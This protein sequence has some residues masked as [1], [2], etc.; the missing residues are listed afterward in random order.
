MTNR[1]FLTVIMG[2][3]ATALAACSPGYMKASEL[4]SKHQGPADC[5]A[6]CVELG[7][8][9][10]ALVLVSDTLPGC[11]CQPTPTVAPAA[12]APTP[13]APASVPAPALS[14]APPAN[15]APAAPISDVSQ[16][17]ASA[18]TASY[19]VATMAAAAAA[20]ANQTE[21]QR[22]TQQSYL[23]K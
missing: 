18:A 2:V 16:Q 12:P 4:E 15:P 8:R 6:R 14:G 9:M 11:V 22:R 1:R 7:M 23:P 21:Q 17:G 13:A 5:Q 20:R 19:V 10:G 3:F